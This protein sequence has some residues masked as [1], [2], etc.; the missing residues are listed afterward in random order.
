MKDM[1][2]Q[3]TEELSK[4]CAVEKAALLALQKEECAKKMEN[5]SGDHKSNAAE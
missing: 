3:T 5:M 2:K 1:K 4:K